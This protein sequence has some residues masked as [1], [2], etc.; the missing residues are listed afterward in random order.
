MRMVSP[1]SA[2]VMAAWM[3]SK[4]P[5]ADQ[6]DLAGF[7]P[8]HDL[9]AGE[10][11]RPFRAASRHRP[12][13]RAGGDVRKIDRRVVLGRVVAVAAFQR[14]VTV[15]AAQRVVAAAAEER[16]LA[17]AASTG[18]PGPAAPL[19]VS[20]AP[21][22]LVPSRRAA[23][24]VV[25]ARPFEIDNVRPVR[26]RIEQDVVAVVGEVFPSWREFGRCCGSAHRRRRGLRR[27]YRSPRCRC[28]R[29]LR[30]PYRGRRCRCS[31]SSDW[32]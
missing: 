21:S 15:A 6:Q 12:F 5:C 25:A 10:R 22:T 16:V 2:A 29:P 3:V 17:A 28:L 26:I 18:R 20:A 1:A 27:R 8:V 13:A 19:I 7:A 23:E 4:P 14:V 9:D 32:C 31:G 24:D 11:V 30:L